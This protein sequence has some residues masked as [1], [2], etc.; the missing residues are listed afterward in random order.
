MEGTWRRIL[1]VTILS[2]VAWPGAATPDGTAIDT[3]KSSIRVHVFQ[4]GLFSALAHNHEVG[5]PVESGEVT[6]TGTLSVEFR[7]DARKLRVLDPDVSA[8]DRAKIQNTMQGPQV[9]DADRYSE[10]HFRCTTVE[11]HGADHWL[12][13]RN[14]DL[15]GQTHPITVEVMLKDALYRGSAVLKQTAFGITPVTVAGGTVKVK[16]ELKIDFQIALSQ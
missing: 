5:A 13:K 14:L 3:V 16:D 4:T 2:C 12:V 6:Q 10:I 8:G 11:P 15:H 1:A 7:V 9:L